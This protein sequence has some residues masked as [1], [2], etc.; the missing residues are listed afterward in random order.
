MREKS[1]VPASPS[2][3]TASKTWVTPVF[4]SAA[5]THSRP[6]PAPHT[7]P[8]PRDRLG[9]VSFVR[10]VSLWLSADACGGVTRSRT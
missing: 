6:A 5:R 8:S 4:S 3:G 7:S 10:R 1:T 9:S 2:Q